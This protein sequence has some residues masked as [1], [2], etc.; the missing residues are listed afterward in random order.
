MNPIRPDLE[1]DGIEI[2]HNLLVLIRDCWSEEPTDR[3]NADTICNLLKGMM[4]K[5]GNLMDHVFNI[6]ED[7]TTNLE[8]EVEDRTKELTAEKKKA[9]VLLGRMLPKYEKI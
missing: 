5:K 8:M 7:Y 9:D 3:P 4:P 1:L 6:L 2:N